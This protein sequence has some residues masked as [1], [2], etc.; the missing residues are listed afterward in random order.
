[1][2]TRMIEWIR[3]MRQYSWL[4]GLAVFSHVSQAGQPQDG[5]QNTLAIVIIL[6]AIALP[7]VVGGIIALV[8]WLVS[9]GTPTPL[10][11]SDQAKVIKREI[12][13]EGVHL[14]P[15]SGRPF[16][17]SL[18]VTIL[19]LGLVVRSFAF[20]FSPDFSVPIFLVLGAIITAIGLF[21]WIG[22]DFRARKEH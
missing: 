14:P 13:P 12:L 6:S 7:F 21:G 3:R 18:G 4:G 20:E 10:N 5:S 9:L 22:D 8:T 19:C 15:P 17:L 11:T 2:H 16:V 1:M